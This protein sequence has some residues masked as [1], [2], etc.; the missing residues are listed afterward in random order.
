MATDVTP[1]AGEPPWWRTPKRRDR[2]RAPL[3]REAIVVAAVRILDREGLDAV[4]IRRLGEELGSGSAT[5]YWHI[6]GKDELFELV[7]DR[8]MGEV[9]LPEPDPSRWQ[10]QLKELGREAFR[11]MRAHNDAVRLSIG[12]VPVG[13]NMLR[14][15][16]W[17]LGLMRAGGVPDHVAAYFGDLFGRYLDASVLEETMSALP[18]DPASSVEARIGMLHDYFAGLPADQFPNIIAMSGAMVRGDADERFELGLE[19]LM[20]GLEAYVEDAADGRGQPPD[21]E[22]TL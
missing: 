8:I 18:G 12:R 15:I 16:E 10:E 7:Y 20:R 4:T 6:T 11:V 9:E 19:I 14:I 5:L 21:R 3:S 22:L 2:A 17:S 13:P 1:R